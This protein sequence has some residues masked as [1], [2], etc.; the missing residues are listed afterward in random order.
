MLDVIFTFLLCALGF[1]LYLAD[2]NNHEISGLKEKLREKEKPAFNAL[3]PP[4]LPNDNTYEIQRLTDLLRRKD[5]EI[6]TLKNSFRDKDNKISD[7]SIVLQRKETE[8][9]RLRS[10]NRE[11]DENVY[12]VANL[13]NELHQR[14]CEISKL[15]GIIH[16]IDGELSQLRETLSEKEAEIERLR[17]GSVTPPQVKKFVQVIFTKGS[18]DRYDYFVG[19]NQ[20][21]QVG[22]FVEVYAGDK[23]YGKPKRTIAQVVYLSKTGEVS[24]YA[25]S[26]IKRKADRPKW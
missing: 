1:F 17:K 4:V 18:T 25:K 24:E 5:D 22:D 8:L 11:R 7:L 16:E 14:Q 9:V 10:I 13:T 21:V 3:P 2:K 23:A 12:K 6:L 26:A 15:R 20:D 19:K